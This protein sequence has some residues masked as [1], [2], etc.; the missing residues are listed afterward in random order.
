MA[1]GYYVSLLQMVSPGPLE[2]KRTG[3]T[4]FCS[5]GGYMGVAVL[6]VKAG[7]VTGNI[8]SKWRPERAE[9]ERERRRRRPKQGAHGG[10]SAF[11]PGSEGV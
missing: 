10:G 9:Q 2:R 5:E 11:L 6:A 7:R 3:G 1:G 4:S 8:G